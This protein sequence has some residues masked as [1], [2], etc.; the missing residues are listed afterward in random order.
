MLHRLVA[1]T[2]LA[3]IKPYHLR[4]DLHLIEVLPTV[5]PDDRP[6]HLRHDNH[7]SQVRLDEVGLLVRLGGLLGFPELLDQTHGFA[8]QTA[9]EPPAGTGVDDVAKLFGG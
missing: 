7:V 3:Q 5:D 8:L 2:E 1:N 4:L 6:D 9:V